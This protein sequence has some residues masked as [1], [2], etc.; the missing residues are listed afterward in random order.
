MP[1]HLLHVH[2]SSKRTV[3]ASR[4]PLQRQDV[5]DVAAHW[6]DTRSS[7]CVA[8]GVPLSWVISRCNHLKATVE[9][10]HLG[11]G[12]ARGRAASRGSTDANLGNLRTAASRA[13]GLALA[14]VAEEAEAQ[15]RNH[16]KAST[17]DDDTDDDPKAE[18]E[19]DARG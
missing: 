15:T 2:T 18:T 17:E 5:G 14:T 3:V 6:T 11:G 8:N 12:P 10:L 4:R 9:V 7:L 1:S 16:A 19:G 13:A